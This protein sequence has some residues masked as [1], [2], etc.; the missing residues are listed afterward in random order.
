[1]SQLTLPTQLRTELGRKVRVLRRQ[2]LIPA[3]VFGKDVSSV[4]LQIDSKKFSSLYKQAGESTLIYL[5]VPKEKAPRPVLIS[6]TTYHP[7]S[8]ELLHVSFHQVNLKEKVTAPVALELVGE[9]P[10]EKDKLGIL[11]QQLDEIEIEALPAD[12]PEHIDV[13]VSVLVAV[14]QAIYVK[15]L[16]L[17]SKLSVKSDLT[18]IVAKIEPL[19]AEEK[20]APAPEAVPTEEGTLAPEGAAPVETKPEAKPAAKAE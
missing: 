15:D 11:V 4:N 12:M 2:G 6:E 1:M 5:D 17:D 18:A 19:A 8:G 9:P 3:S 14:D 13:D 16:K 10:A 20:V 7:V